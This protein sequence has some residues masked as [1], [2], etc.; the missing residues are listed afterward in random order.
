[1]QPSCSGQDIIIERSDYRPNV[2]L[3][4]VN[5]Q[6]LVFAARRV[7]DPDSWQ[8]PQGGI[9]DGEQ[10]VSAALREL[11][12]ETNMEN[13]EVVASMS[14]W[15]HYVFPTVSRS[16]TPGVFYRYKG[17]KQKWYMLRFNGDDSEIDLDA[18]HK[19]FLEW[20]W[21][22]LDYVAANVVP[23]K[24]HVYLQLAAEFGPI[25]QHLVRKG[26]VGFGPVRKQHTRRAARLQHAWLLGL[27]NSV[28]S[29]GL[30]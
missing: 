30:H 19:E 9:D 2:G 27:R 20:R 13:V 21:L 11:R 14:Q 4:V 25:I 7:D 5:K 3:C 8:M 23:F 28:S 29:P 18:N 17:Q 1:M 26:T 15:V 22:P 10:P 6:G 24:K 16:T 12:E